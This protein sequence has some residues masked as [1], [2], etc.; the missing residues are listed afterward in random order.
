M[1]Q[2]AVVGSCN[3]DLVVTCT[4]LPR[5][6]ETVM[7]DSLTTVPGGKGANQAVAC[8]RAGARTTLIGA[9]GAGAQGEL[10]VASLQDAAVD[11]SRLRTVSRPTG[12]ALI[13][14]DAA[15]ENLIAVVPGANEA[16]V[17]L[18]AG[19]RAAIA[20]ASVLLLQLEIP[21]PTAI[22]AAV[23]A[24]SSGTTVVLNA[25]PPRRLPPELLAATDLLVVNE[26]EAAELCGGKGADPEATARALL[27]RV[28]AAVITLGAAG[29]L[30]GARDGEPVRVQ[31]PA[32]RAVDTT[33]A[34]DTFTGVL[35]V[36]LA[37]HRPIPEALRRACA[38]ASIAVERLGASASIPARR[39]IDARFAE[40]YGTR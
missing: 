32:V 17:G 34:G 7:C 28:P 2:V 12:T 30:Y 26:H 35:A 3:V 25:A 13:M 4:A 27:A 22:E 20:G 21:L 11:V 33:A 31:A 5:P 15:G 40:V 29:A 14:V 19:D 16:L 23:A 36:G 37:E 9:V 1:T 38:A 6:G 18:T 10:V 39:E 8:A 24:R